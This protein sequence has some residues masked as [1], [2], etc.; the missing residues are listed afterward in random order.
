MSHGRKVSVIGL[1][2][3]GLPVAVA[4][5]TST[6]R[7]VA[8]DINKARIAQLEAGHDAT[9][10]VDDHE[11]AAADLLLSADPQDLREA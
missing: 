3:V 9:G 5:G 4:F 1:G 10:E 7:V 11:L 2:Y 8:F 6:G